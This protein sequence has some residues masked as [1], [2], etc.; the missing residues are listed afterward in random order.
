MGI[1]TALII[2]LIIGFIIGVVVD[3]E[4]EGSET[5]TRQSKE[6]VSNRYET[7]EDELETCED[8]IFHSYREKEA[9][10]TKKYAEYGFEL[11]TPEETESKINKIKENDNKGLLIFHGGCLQ[12]QTPINDGISSCFGCKYFTKDLEHG[13][14]KSTKE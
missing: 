6:E 8:F 2:G 12:C 4:S 1:I 5:P 10:K 3:S 13:E 14:D 7:N 9:V 11:D